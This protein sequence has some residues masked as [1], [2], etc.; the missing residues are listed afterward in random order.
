MNINPNSVTTKDY[1]NFSTD[2]LIK[3]VELGVSTPN[4]QKARHN[5]SLAFQKKISTNLLN[6]PQLNSKHV[7]D[8]IQYVEAGG[9]NKNVLSKYNINTET[10]DGD[11]LVINHLMDALDS[12]LSYG[13][14]STHENLAKYFAQINVGKVKDEA[15]QRE[16]IKLEIEQF[17]LTSSSAVR[18]PTGFDKH[19]DW[20]DENN[21]STLMNTGSEQFSNTVNE[22]LNGGVYNPKFE[23]VQE[24][25]NTFS[26]VKDPKTGNTISVLKS[27]GILN[28]KQIAFLQTVS[29]VS[30]LKGSA[31]TADIVQNLGNKST[32]DLN[33]G[34]SSFFSNVD[35]KEISEVGLEKAVKE[36]I[37]LNTSDDSYDPTLYKQYKDYLTYM[38]A[39]G[40]DE[41]TIAANLKQ[42]HDKEFVEDETFID[43]RFANNFN[44]TNLGFSTIFPDE[45]R[46][47]W[48]ESHI[49]TT[50]NK[51]GYSLNIGN[52]IKSS[53]IPTRIGKIEKKLKAGTERVFLVPDKT[54][55]GEGINWFPHKVVGGELVPLIVEDDNGIIMPGFNEKELR[56]DF[57]ASEASSSLSDYEIEQDRKFKIALEKLNYLEKVKIAK[58]LDGF[59]S[60]KAVEE[61]IISNIKEENTY[62]F[63]VGE[64]SNKRTYK[65]VKNSGI[66]T[67][68][69]LNS[70]NEV[71]QEA[72][73]SRILGQLKGV[74]EEAYQKVFNTV[75]DMKD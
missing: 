63:S 30:R 66:G 31:F 33:E 67:H 50:L 53:I 23:K 51:Y 61:S 43:S 35:N 44:K 42:I 6:D 68:A 21:W 3:A 12:V 74:N 70:N 75:F 64:L 57:T 15:E 20:T 17:E 5:L 28:D 36:F 10:E 48:V 13:S 29:D 69:I 34:L 46:R 8:V 73:L 22:F 58:E 56:E 9:R 25:F 27:K 14:S 59:V 39:T 24:I 62:T 41:A 55:S 47:K 18:N 2:W 11:P 7:L 54:S 65:Y 71:M 49:E 1:I 26:N 60:G 38:V 72:A 19:F 45:N 40:F 37:E 16:I 32:Q 4:F 52:D